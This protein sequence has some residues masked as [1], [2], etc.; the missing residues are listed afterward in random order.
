M[1]SR[2]ASLAVWLRR[3][4]RPRADQPESGLR[5]LNPRIPAK[6]VDARIYLTAMKD[7]KPD[8]LDVLQI[9]A[10]SVDQPRTK[11]SC[12]QSRPTTRQRTI[13]AGS[14]D[15]SRRRDCT[16]RHD[17]NR[18]AV[19]DGT[20]ISRAVCSSRPFALCRS[21]AQAN[22]RQVQSGRRSAARCAAARL[23]HELRKWTRKRTR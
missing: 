14:R 22:S 13:R 20:N 16:C 5:I 1:C 4:D 19:C 9:T 10:T 6:A 8:S 17:D 3:R 11:L 18:C 23:E 12:E 7:W 2:P 15:A 21:D